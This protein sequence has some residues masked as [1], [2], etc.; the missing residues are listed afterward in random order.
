MT[1][2]RW[3][4]KVQDWLKDW[5]QVGVHIA[6]VTFLCL[7]FAL[8]VLAFGALIGWIVYSVV[9]ALGLV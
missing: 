1:L 7:A 3:L 4:T 9:V 8:L 2:Y 6:M 5:L